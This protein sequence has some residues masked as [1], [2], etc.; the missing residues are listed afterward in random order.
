MRVVNLVQ[1]HEILSHAE[2]MGYPHSSAHHFLFAVDKIGP[3]YEEHHC[4]YSLGD[5][6]I[7]HRQAGKYYSN[8][9]SDYHPDTIKV[10]L[11]FMKSHQVK[12]ITV[13]L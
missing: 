6:D 3:Y 4:D 5:F 11:S 1:T 10:M 2:Q 7:V 9:P 13:I 8:N 12:E